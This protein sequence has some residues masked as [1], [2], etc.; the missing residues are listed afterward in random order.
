MNKTKAIF[1]VILVFMLGAVC[2]AMGTHMI[3]RNRSDSFMKGTP[4]SRETAIVSHLT[5]KLELDSRQQSQISQI[6]HENHAAMNRIRTQY[7]PQIQSILEQG[8]SRIAAILTQEQNTAF[9]KIIEERKRH[10]F[11]DKP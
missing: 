5:R 7:R 9:Q 4:E 3:N 6:I 10:H 1:G 8:Q 2:G 11:Q